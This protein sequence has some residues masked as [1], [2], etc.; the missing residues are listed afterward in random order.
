MNKFEIIYRHNDMPPDYRG[1]KRLWANTPSQAL[2]YMC[3]RK[4]DN[5]GRTNLK[6]GG[7][8]I[9]I[10]SVNEISNEL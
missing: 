5:N 3:T 4:P 2:S 9:I 1:L 7:A 10:E 6:K 8:S